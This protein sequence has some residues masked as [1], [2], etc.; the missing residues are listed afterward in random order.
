MDKDGHQAGEMV[1]SFFLESEDDPELN[2][3]APDI[4]KSGPHQRCGWVVITH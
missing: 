2:E 3:L 4:P 1:V